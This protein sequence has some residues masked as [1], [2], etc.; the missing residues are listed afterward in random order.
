MNWFQVVGCELVSEDIFF[1]YYEQDSENSVVSCVGWSRSYNRPGV[2]FCD[3][4]LRY[5]ATF[6]EDIITRLHVQD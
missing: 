5:F 1:W 6:R 2:S 4:T 3:V